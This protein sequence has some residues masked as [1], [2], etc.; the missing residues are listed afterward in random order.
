MQLDRSKS[1]GTIVGHEK[2]HFIQNGKYFDAGGEQVVDKPAAKGAKTQE[3]LPSADALASAKEFLTTLLAGG[4]VA[5]PNVYK[6]AEANNQI[7]EDVKKAKMD[8]NIKTYQQG[9]IEMWQI[10]A[11]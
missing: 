4:P 6:E 9:K 10:T 2:Y 8:M 3:E 5:K 7:W 1:Y 11:A